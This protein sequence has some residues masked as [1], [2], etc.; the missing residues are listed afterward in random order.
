[1]ATRLQ[2]AAGSASGPWLRVGQEEHDAY[3]CGY[4][5]KLVGTMSVEPFGC[6]AAEV[7][8]AAIKVLGHARR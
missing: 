4:D 2:K 7:P 6:P 1:M 5:Q 8:P 3:A